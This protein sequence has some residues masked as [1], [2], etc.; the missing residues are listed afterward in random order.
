MRFWPEMQYLSE[1]LVSLPLRGQANRPGGGMSADAFDASF[2]GQDELIKL[3]GAE[4]LTSTPRD[5]PTNLLM[6]P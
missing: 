3:A 1:Q 6:A 4:G 2:I 5:E